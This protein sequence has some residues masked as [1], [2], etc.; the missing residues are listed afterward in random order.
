MTENTTLGDMVFEISEKY[1]LHLGVARS[2]VQG[3]AVEI[4]AAAFNANANL[5]DFMN[6][7]T[8]ETPAVPAAKV[9]AA[10]VAAK[11]K[12]VKLSK[13]Q[14]EFLGSLNTYG[15]LFAYDSTPFRRTALSLMAKG[16]VVEVKAYNDAHDY[17][18]TEAGRAA[19]K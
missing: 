13:R 8:T 10:P 19:L 14:R 18:I 9:E 2:I 3:H 4:I 12:T 5:N 1:N 11:A 17:D 7:L 6:A 15:A 16:L